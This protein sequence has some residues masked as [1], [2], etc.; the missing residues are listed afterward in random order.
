LNNFIDRN[1]KMRQLSEGKDENDN[2]IKSPIVSQITNATLATIKSMENGKF[3]EFEISPNRYKKP[4]RVK[5]WSKNG[6]YIGSKKVKSNK[7][8]V[9]IIDISFS[10]RSQKLNKSQATLPEIS[11]SE[12]LLPKLEEIYKPQVIQELLQN[13]SIL[14]SDLV[15]ARRSK[16]SKKNVDKHSNP[17]QYGYSKVQDSLPEETYLPNIKFGKLEEIY[18]PQAIQK[19]H[20][21]NFILYSD[22]VNSTQWKRL[23]ED[24][25]ML[26]NPGDYRY[27]PVQEIL[28]R[29]CHVEV[30]DYRHYLPD[31]K[32]KKMR[33]LGLE[34]RKKSSRRKSL[35]VNEKSEPTTIVSSDSSFEMILK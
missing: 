2:F 6:E 31:S 28:R 30:G 32:E 21:K 24:T 18:E 25:D 9:E 10:D 26:Y 5:N 14:Y 27:I 35:I 8:A 11:N 20:S 29:E 4:R 34:Y 12:V 1:G 23:E 22:L 17:S 33:A 7:N 13:K 19:L 15:N 3:D 16:S